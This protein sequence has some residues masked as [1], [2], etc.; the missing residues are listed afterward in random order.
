M[1][2]EFSQIRVFGL[3]YWRRENFKMGDSIYELHA[4]VHHSVVFRNLVFTLSNIRIQ[5][6]MSAWGWL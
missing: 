6:Q 1:K 2:M 4:Y 5:S 3:Q